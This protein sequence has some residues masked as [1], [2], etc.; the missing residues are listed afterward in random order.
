MNLVKDK[1]ITVDIKGHWADDK[2]LITL[3]RKDGIST[4]HFNFALDDI[5]LEH[6]ISTL[7]VLQR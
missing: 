4:E 5:D 1:N 3:I 7:I 6:L 2:L